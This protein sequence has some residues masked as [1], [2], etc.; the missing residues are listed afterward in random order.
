MTSERQINSL[1]GLLSP[2]AAYLTLY[3]SIAPDVQQYVQLPSK[4]IDL[5]E[6]KKRILKFISMSIPAINR[7]NV[8][9]TIVN[10]HKH[11]CDQSLLYTWT[12]SKLKLLL[13]LNLTALW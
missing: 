13:L 1:P 10:F 9:R 12:Y 8:F 11:T 4:F 5:N 2:L 7:F 3:W 6:M